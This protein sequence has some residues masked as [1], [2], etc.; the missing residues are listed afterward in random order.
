MNRLEAIA[1][2]RDTAEHTRKRIAELES[3]FATPCIDA[4][5]YVVVL[6]SEFATP[7]ALKI[8]DA[9]TNSYNF[10]AQGRDAVQYSKPRAIEVAK[11]VSTAER[12]AKPMG[13][14]D[15]FKLQLESAREVLAQ[16]EAW[17]A[18]AEKAE[19]AAN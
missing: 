13:K 14:Y 6:H 10:S 1:S 16:F 7:S 9:A 2:F 5:P 19:A 18:E 15:F 11:A 17:I 3:Y 8:V 4:W 12:K